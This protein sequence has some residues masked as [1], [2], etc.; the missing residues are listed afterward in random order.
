MACADKI[1]GVWWSAS[2]QR[3]RFLRREGWADSSYGFYEWRPGH[4]VPHETFTTQDVFSNCQMLGDQL[5]CNR[6]ASRSP[7]QIVLLDPATGK[8]R[9][10]FDAKPE[11]AS[12]SLGAVTRLHWR[13]AYGTACYGDLVLPPDHRP[14]QR[15]PLVI[16]QYRTR[17]FLRGAIGDQYPIQVF[18]ARVMRCSAS[19]AFHFGRKPDPGPVITAASSNIRWRTRPTGS[20]GATCCR[21]S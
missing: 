14:G 7:R 3:L 9:A 16:V 2:G 13:N 10:V 5:I 6:E 20:T 8:W 11:F 21:R 4:G 15:H 1:I 12:R 19:S 17:G 18:A